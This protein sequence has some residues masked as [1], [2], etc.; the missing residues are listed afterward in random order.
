MTD[1]EKL[2]IL[3]KP[4]TENIS[5]IKMDIEKIIGKNQNEPPLGEADGSFN[6]CQWI[7]AR[8]ISTALN[9]IIINMYNM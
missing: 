1:I 7:A 8:D 4:I 9:T 2:R 5:A 6:E 3:L